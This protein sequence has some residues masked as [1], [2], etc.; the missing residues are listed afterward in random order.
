MRQWA[1]TVDDVPEPVPQSGQALQVSEEEFRANL[2]R[3][4]LTRS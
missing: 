3:D 2:K 4:R 1:L